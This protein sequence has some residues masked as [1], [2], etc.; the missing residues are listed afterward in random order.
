MKDEANLVIELNDNSAIEV[1][2]YDLSG[3]VVSSVFSGQVNAGK[4]EFKIDT[5]EFENGIYYTKIST[6]NSLK[7]IK[8]VVSK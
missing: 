7:T 2:V 4:T 5:N 3:K 8:M 1:V 6:A